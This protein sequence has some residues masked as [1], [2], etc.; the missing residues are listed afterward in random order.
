[1]RIINDIEARFPVDEWV[2]NGIKVW[3]ILRIHLNFQLQ[4][5][6]EKCFAGTTEA[7]KSIINNMIDFGTQL[8][9]DHLALLRDYAHN[10]KLHDTKVAISKAEMAQTEKDAKKRIEL[11]KQAF[12]YAKQIQNPLPVYLIHL[13]LSCFVHHQ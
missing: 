8:A 1:M 4:Y 5:H 2:V 10:Q 7:K 13:R 12:D 3:P 9:K 11:Q 6:E